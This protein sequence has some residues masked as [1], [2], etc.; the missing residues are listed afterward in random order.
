VR[1]PSLRKSAAAGAPTGKR[2]GNYRHGTHTKEATQAVRLASEPTL[3]A[4]VNKALAELLAEGKV[5]DLGTQAG[6][7]YLPPRT[8]TAAR[9]DLKHAL[10][11]T[12]DT[13]YRAGRYFAH[14]RCFRELGLGI[15]FTDR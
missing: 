6:L 8:N 3:L 14:V 4:A 13:E 1:R 11:M 12:S 2:N 10:A 7:T 9:Q 15:R 5:A